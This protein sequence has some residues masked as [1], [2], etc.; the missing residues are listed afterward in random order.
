M[1]TFLATMTLIIKEYLSMINTHK[2]TDSFL[3]SGTEK[4]IGTIGSKN[5]L[6]V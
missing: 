5:P 4:T 1:L 3:A 2:P 6:I